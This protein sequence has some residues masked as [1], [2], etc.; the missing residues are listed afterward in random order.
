MTDQARKLLEELMAPYEG[1]KKDF[2]DKDVCK[3]YLV[4]FCPNLQFTNTKAGLGACDLVHDD[5]LKRDYEQ[6]RDKDSLSYER[7][8][9]RRLHVLLTDLDRKIRQ[10]FNRINSEADEKLLNPDKEEWIEKSIM[11]EEKIKQLLEQAE[12]YGEE[13]KVNEAKAISSQIEGLQS[14]LSG[15]KEKIKA[16]NP[17]FKNEKKLEVCDVCGAL[18]VPDE[19]TKR[20]DAH[21]EGKQHQG[22]MKIREALAEYNKAAMVI[23]DL[24]T[25]TGMTIDIGAEDTTMRTGDRITGTMI[26][27]A[28]DLVDLQSKYGI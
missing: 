4:G 25:G 24:R 6:Y 11:I 13:G 15:V 18:L 19:D 28:I 22:Y 26:D 2:R 16:V 23:G 21:I 7:D 27:I 8:F 17:M 14:E 12:K 3:D 1:K 9:Y 5:S 10:A 20:L